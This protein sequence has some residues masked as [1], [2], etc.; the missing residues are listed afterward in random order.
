MRGLDRCSSDCAAPIFI[1]EPLVETH[2]RLNQRDHFVVVSAGR[3]VSAHP[4]AVETL[5][6]GFG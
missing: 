6:L 5:I 2:A 1:V 3:H 4:R